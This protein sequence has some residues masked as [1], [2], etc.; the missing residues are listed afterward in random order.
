MQKKRS[1]ECVM[2]G[3]SFDRGF[4]FFVLEA[5]VPFLGG[6]IL[7]V[8]SV[9]C[10]PRVCVSTLE[11]IPTVIVSAWL[12]FRKKKWYSADALAGFSVKLK[13]CFELSELFGFLLSG[14]RVVYCL[15]PCNCFLRD[16][17]R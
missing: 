16:I 14:R 1:I 2:E 13:P 10:E 17:G 9:C 11:H 3:V 4:C 7:L 8:Q 6:S 5:E 15:Q 12:Q